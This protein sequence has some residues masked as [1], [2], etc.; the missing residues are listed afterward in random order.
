MPEQ[1][2]EY[3]RNYSFILE[4]AGARAGYFKQI[5]NLGVSLQVI[6][7]REG[8]MPSTVHKLPG[9]ASVRNVRLSHGLTASDELW[10]WLDTALQGRVE[11][12]NVSIIVLSA[13]GQ[14][15]VTRWNLG[16]A[17]LSECQ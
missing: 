9:R 1:Q 5:E 6:E 2:P 15:E 12:R 3:F 11:R 16:N 17:W 7:Y 14:T 4:M 10:R 8:G 13:D